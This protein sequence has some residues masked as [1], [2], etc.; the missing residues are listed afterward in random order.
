MVRSSLWCLALL[1]GCGPLPCKEPEPRARVMRSVAPP[2]PGRYLDFERLEFAAVFVGEDG[3]VMQYDG[4]SLQQVESGTTATLRGMTCGSA[5][6]ILLAV[7]DAGAVRISTD[8]GWTWVAGDSETQ[9]DLYAVGLRDNLEG[10]WPFAIA[11]GDGVAL[12]S[13]DL[14][15]SWTPLQLP[16]GDERLRDLRA[17]DDGWLA[18]GEGGVILQAAYDAAIWQAMASPTEDDLRRFLLRGILG[19]DSL[20]IGEP[21]AW[22]P[23]ALPLTGEIADATGQTLVMRDGRLAHVDYPAEWDYAQLIVEEPLPGVQR[24]FDDSP[25]SVTVLADDGRLIEVA[26]VTIDAASGE[27][28][29]PLAEL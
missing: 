28:C 15:Q 7:G 21:G 26:F 10:G 23:Q 13:D 6:Q 17:V 5:P 24:I 14:G 9:A 25:E 22:H 1:G 3:R 20:L 16:T 12:R 18:I 8:E 4:V 11:V 2:E 29:V 19:V 27:V